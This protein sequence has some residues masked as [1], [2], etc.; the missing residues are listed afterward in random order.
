MTRFIHSVAA[1]LALSVSASAQSEF[2]L[3]D[4]F[5]ISLFAS[6]TNGVVKPI[7]MRFDYRGRLW[8][9][10]STV[11]PQIEPGQIPDDKVL[12]L[13]DTDHDG[14]CDKTTVF[15]SGLMI[16]TGLEV[17]KD[18]VYVGHGTELLFLKDTDG[19][20][21]ADER[22][23]VLRGFG[24]GDNHQ[25]INSFL[26]GPGG[27][28]W[29]SQGLH[30]HSNVETPW[31]LIRME[32]AGLWRFW[33]KRLKLQAFYGA[34]HEPQNPWG[35]VFTDWG[36][37]IVMA[38][39]NSSPIYPVP[40]LVSRRKIEAPPL[41]WRNGNGRKVSG[42]DIVGTAHFPDEWQ[43][44]LIAGGY[45]NNAVWGLSI[46]EDGAGFAL[47][48][49]KPL[50][51]TTNRTFRPVDVKFGPDGAL[52]ICDWYNPIIGHY[53]ASFRHPDRDKTHGRIWRVTAKGRALTEP[54]D[55]TH[56]DLLKYLESPDRWTRQFAKRAL[57]EVPVEPQQ[58]SSE[59]AQKEMLGLMQ[60][61]EIV[62]PELVE[63]LTPAKNPGARA[64]AANVIG[65]WAD[66]LTNALAL[67]RPLASDPHPRVRLQAIVAS[68]YI[69]SSDAIE[70][71]AIA[72]E[73]PT[74][75]FLEYGLNQAVFAL[76][77]YWLPTLKPGPYL[78]IIVQRDR[79]PDT[80]AA[81]RTMPR[82]TAVVELLA[83]I[84]DA[85][86][87]NEILNLGTPQALRALAQIARA[88]TTRPSCDLAAALRPHLKD[89]NAQALAGIWKVSALRDDL[90]RANAI[91]ALADL[92]DREAILSYA[93]TLNPTAIA[94]L[95]RFDLAK[96]ASLAP[97]VLN[98]EIVS[99]FLQRKAGAAALAD[100]LASHPPNKQ[101]AEMILRVMNSSG[102]RDEKLARLVSPS[103]QGF[104]AADLIPLVRANGN[105]KRGDEIFHRPELGCIAC[106]SVNGQGGSIG[107]DLSALGTAQ[108]LDFI[109]GAILEPQKEIKEGYMSVSI[110]TN[111]G[112]ELQGYLRA[113]SAADL[114]IHDVLQNRDIRLPRSRIKENRQNGSVMPTGLV[115]SLSREQFADLIR[116]LSELGHNK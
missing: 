97:A 48:D 100:A 106:H 1:V 94:M 28:L 81:L 85:N 7:Q 95:T 18:G 30:I 110:V 56:G 66:R 83:E 35:Y 31:G 109:I 78:R 89:P 41:I 29:M 91:E 102:R 50:I 58:L 104:S 76:K 3:A 14:R 61:H 111:D 96:A 72:S 8:V 99:A 67:L 52:Y 57:A 45:I 113:E 71:A 12:I 60:A 86:D 116:Y 34:E 6:E 10:G 38:G 15:A 88:R 21:K 73:H 68:T 17:V 64:Y 92:G 39:N 70:I 74:D 65:S 23:V 69:P 107:P 101:T 27:E 103:T 26:W 84:G 51:T 20:G 105:A 44:K 87:L 93:T 42:A 4:G 24:T 47:E 77:P 108:P 79:T 59:L 5:E 115:N 33:P 98:E 36:E 53:Q 22:K 11:Y 114:T 82:D 55:L 9:I 16:P 80:L 49:F 46:I 90:R 62:A 54:P 19:D 25:N 13:E 43:G 75:K 63:K 40:G 2:Q 112:E 32:Q 37:P